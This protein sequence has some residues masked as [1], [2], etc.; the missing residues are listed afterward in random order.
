MLP[1]AARDAPQETAISDIISHISTLVREGEQAR[2]ALTQA[3]EQAEAAN[4]AKS[5]FLANMSH[6]IRTPMN[7]MIG[8]LELCLDTKLSA[9]QQEYLNVAQRSAENLLVIINDILDFSKIEANKIE[10][11]NLSIDLPQMLKDLIPVHQNAA[12][13]KI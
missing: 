3:K 8:M 9:E 11:E 6:E 1:P 13:R 7:G 12:S 5:D 4:R 10:I 2:L